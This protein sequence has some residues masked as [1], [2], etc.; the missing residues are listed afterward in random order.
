MSTISETKKLVAEIG[1][2]L[3]ELKQSLGT[4]KE[5]FDNAKAQAEN[6]VR[7]SSTDVEQR[8]VAKLQQ[9]AERAET[10]QLAVSKATEACNS[11]AS[12]TL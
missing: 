1:T 2:S 8:L 3:A 9:A 4:S 11:Y 10:A 7:G 5:Q 6:V 12:Q